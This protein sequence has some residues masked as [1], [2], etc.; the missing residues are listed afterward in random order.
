M[1]Y[2]IAK[3]LLIDLINMRRKNIV[4]F[5][6]RIYLEMGRMSHMKGKTFLL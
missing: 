3:R 6:I 4:S 1:I 2:N 5:L